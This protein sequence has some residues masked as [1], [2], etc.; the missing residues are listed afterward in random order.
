M[1]CVASPLIV[2]LLG[3]AAVSLQ[4]CGDTQAVQSNAV[5][6]SKES[7]TKRNYAAEQVNESKGHCKDG[8][9][10][11]TGDHPD[12][13]ALCAGWEKE[14]S[15]QAVKEKETGRKFENTWS[16][17]HRN[18]KAECVDGKFKCYGDAAWCA[19]QEKAQEWCHGGNTH[20]FL[21]QRY[22][23]QGRLKI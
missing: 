22:H 11:C 12:H 6:T 23:S 9:F 8:K 17:K 16:K 19:E 21:Q 1:R 14:C 2:C 3:F 20:L 13:N 10:T 5:G 4:G 15:D 7:N 18:S